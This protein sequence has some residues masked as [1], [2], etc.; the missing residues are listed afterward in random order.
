MMEEGIN[1]LQ[2]ED[3]RA[4]AVLVKKI[5]DRSKLKTNISVVSDGEKAL[6]YL[7]HRGDYEDRDKYPRPDLVLLDLRLPK[8]DGTGVLKRI[9][10]QEH[11][12]DLPVV[13]FTSSERDEDI[14]RTYEDGAGGYLLKSAF[15]K[16][17]T[18]MDGLLDIILSLT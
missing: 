8:L 9:R 15:A 17:S 5:L 18:K 2:V 6:D 7:F 14:I 3:S 10:E 13:I 16:K 11:L 12:K 4:D 1:I